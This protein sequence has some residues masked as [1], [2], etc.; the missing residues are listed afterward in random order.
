MVECQHQVTDDGRYHGERQDPGLHHEE[1]GDDDG[2]I[3]PHLQLAGADAKPVLNKQRQD[4]EAAQTRFVAEHDEQPHA[5]Q[6]AADQC[7]VDRLNLADLQHGVEV[8]RHEGDRHHRDEGVEGEARPHPQPRQGI[9][10]QVHGEEQQAE[11]QPRH[12]LQQ[13][14]QPGGAA[15]EQ[16]DLMKQKDAE[17]DEAGRGQQGD[18]VFIEGVR[19]P[20]GVRRARGVVHNRYPIAK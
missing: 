19:S 16:T 2:A 5:D 13:Q 20:N 3:Q 18:D 12:L 4:V 15:G 9:E 10:G 14:R 8:I 6:G 1:G 11:A 17:G 7:S